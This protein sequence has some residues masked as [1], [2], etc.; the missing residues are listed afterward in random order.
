MSFVIRK[1]FKLAEKNLLWIEEHDLKKDRFSDRGSLRLF[2]AKAV[3]N[4]TSLF[5]KK[6]KLAT[7]I[8][9]QR[10]MQIMS[11]V[12][13]TITIP[14]TIM[15][16]VQNEFPLRSESLVDSGKEGGGGVCHL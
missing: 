15:F 5:E 8:G 14:I 7:L 1:M 16:C 4:R 3:K 9:A 11:F 2:P 13:C 12:L 6:A 10:R